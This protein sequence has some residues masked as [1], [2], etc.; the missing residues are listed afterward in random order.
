[1]H[2]EPALLAAI[3]ADPEDDLPRLA[4]ADWLDEHGNPERAEF[5]R[6]ECELARMGTRE[7]D[8][9]N[10]EDEAR[11]LTLHARTRDLWKACGGGWF[12]GLRPY[13]GAVGT[14]RGFPDTLAMSVRRFVAH[15]ER[16]F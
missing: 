9:A 10:E 4:Y 15:G 5:I 3:L 1:M 6:V 7:E 16:V 13:L 8:E 14:A 11:A 2:E 12:P